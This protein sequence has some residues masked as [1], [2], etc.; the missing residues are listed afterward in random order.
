M[1][2]FQP[3]AVR[4]VMLSSEGPRQDAEAAEEADDAA[5]DAEVG[6]SFFCSRTENPTIFSPER[7][8]KRK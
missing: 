3:C 8:L 2:G 4:S 6:L 5:G 7:L 1:E